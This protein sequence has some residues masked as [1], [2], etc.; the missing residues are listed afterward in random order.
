MLESNYAHTVSRRS[1]LGN[2]GK[3]SRFPCF[4][5]HSRQTHARYGA[6]ISTIN[7][8]FDDDYLQPIL[9]SNQLYKH[10]LESA[11]SCIEIGKNATL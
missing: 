1:L 7:E 2:V 11:S 8:A 3:L 10:T 4:L 6:Q 5:R 9:Y